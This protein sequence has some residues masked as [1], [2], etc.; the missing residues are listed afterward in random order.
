MAINT[1]A[2]LKTAMASWL[3]RTDLTA[4]LDD[5][6]A[7]GE[8]DIRND[9]RIQAMEQY[10]IGTLT[11][12][13]LAHPTR[14]L[15][16][17]RL[18]VGGVN[19]RYVTPEVYAAAV[20]AGSTQAIFTAIGQSFYILGGT[21]GDAYT[22]IYYAAFAPM[23]ADGD[24]NWL[25]TNYPNVYLFG[26]CRQAGIFLEDDAKINK[27]TTLYQDAVGRLVSRERQSAVSGSALVMRSGTTE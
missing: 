26:A 9:V 20:E 27:Y 15:E 2:T 17:R 12:E 4:Q 22:L 3:D 21:S 11:G 1:Y 5:F 6:V 7:L 13:T 25:L 19:F 18:T 14:Y 10:T 24:T 16:A 8:V 23:T